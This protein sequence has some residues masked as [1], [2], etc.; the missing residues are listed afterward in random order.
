MTKINIILDIDSVDPCDMDP[1]EIAEGILYEYT[2]ARK[3]TAQGP[4]A[5]FVSAE[6]E[7]P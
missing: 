4:A 3:S 2:E 1:W 5:T 6:W 7:T